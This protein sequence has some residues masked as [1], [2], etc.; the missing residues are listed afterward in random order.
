MDALIELARR[1]TQ[2]EVPAGHVFWSVGEPASYSIRIVYGRVRCTAADGSE[3][4]VGAEFNL[5]G[6]DAWSMQPRSYAAI[7]ETDVVGYRTELDEF[8]EVLELHPDL[9]LSLLGLLARALI[10][11]PGGT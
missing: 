4:K 9:A 6:M 11:M 10:E 3:V 1:T 2:F 7:A 5:G 8:L